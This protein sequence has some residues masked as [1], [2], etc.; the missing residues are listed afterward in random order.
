M[1]MLLAAQDNGNSVQCFRA[2]KV[3]LLGTGWE[4][5]DWVQLAHN[6]SQVRV[7]VKLRMSF[8]IPQNGGNF[9]TSFISEGRQLLKLPVAK[10]I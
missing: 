2:S 10:C 3:D 9:L 4:C 8:W 7:T 5:V 1:C 6:I